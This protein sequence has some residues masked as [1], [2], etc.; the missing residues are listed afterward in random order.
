MKRLYTIIVALASVCYLC[1]QE[2]IYV[3]K[4]NGS[5]EAISLDQLDSLKLV[6]TSSDLQLTAEKDTVRLG[7]SVSLETN[8]LEA[9]V[10]AVAQLI[11]RFGMSL[12]GGIVVEFHC[13][14]HIKLHTIAIGMA[15]T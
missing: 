6:T 2:K 7:E 15:Y 3:H 4:T 10:V 5:I 1:A 11:L 13:F 14:S 9:I 8:I 12:L